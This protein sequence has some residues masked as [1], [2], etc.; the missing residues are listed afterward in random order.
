[1]CF[2]NNDKYMGLLLIFEGH[3]SIFD[4]IFH[5]PTK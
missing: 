4:M 5:V 1:M 3:A 2:V